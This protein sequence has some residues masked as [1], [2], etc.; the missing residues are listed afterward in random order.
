MTLLILW[1]VTPLTLPCQMRA[2]NISIRVYFRKNGP[3]FFAFKIDFA[4]V[5]SILTKN[6]VS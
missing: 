5:W 1:I 4:V 2:D 6:C 3:P